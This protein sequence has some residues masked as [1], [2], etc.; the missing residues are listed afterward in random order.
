MHWFLRVLAAVV[1]AA[2][3]GFFSTAW[4][5]GVTLRSGFGNSGPFDQP[6]VLIAEL[7]AVPQNPSVGSCQLFKEGELVDTQGFT[8][9]AA[10]FSNFATLA[11]GT[12]RFS[13][14]CTDSV[15]NITT[16][17]VLSYEVTK[18][19]P[20][21]YVDITKT[22]GYFG[23][24]AEIG[25]N[26]I[27]ARQ[28]DMGPIELYD[29]TKLIGSATIGPR[30]GALTFQVNGLAIGPHTLTAHY[31]GDA[32]FFEET[33][34]PLTFTI[35]PARI[36]T[37]TVVTVSQNPGICSKTFH[38]LRASRALQVYPTALFTSMMRVLNHRGIS[39][40]ILW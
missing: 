9:A 30:Y 2:F 15:G 25:V 19:S 18:A 39:R 6:L 5:G 17:N 35:L 24:T 21:L 28:V 29:G 8:Y 20:K 26:V 7:S 14:R 40:T 23:E 12:Y 33:S 11:I 32:L 34:A 36:A 1:C 27:S 13:A 31:G 10:I 16:S 37:T 22:T 3:M 38:F 4:A